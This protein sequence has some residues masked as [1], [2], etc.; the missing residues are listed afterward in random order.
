MS[1][2][3]AT[4]VGPGRVCFAAFQPGPASFGGEPR[5]VGRDVPAQRIGGPAV[6]RPVR[7]T[8][9]SPRPPVDDGAVA[10]PDHVGVA[11]P[12]QEFRFVGP[13]DGAG[14]DRAE[15]S[16]RYFPGGD[17]EAE[18]RTE[19]AFSDLEAEVEGIGALFGTIIA[20]LGAE[21]FFMDV[22]SVIVANFL[23]SRINF[24]P[25]SDGGTERGRHLD[26]V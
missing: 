19:G 10:P 25:S 5:I 14:V 11:E 21:E 8:A 7:A 3:D 2:V 24:L 4:N 9:E 15:G 17:E 26:V 12:P 20:L 13:E 1:A 6:E 23:S 18:A 22:P 16:G